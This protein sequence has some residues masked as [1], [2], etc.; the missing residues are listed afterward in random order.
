MMMPTIGKTNSTKSEKTSKHSI[1]RLYFSMLRTANLLIII[2]TFLVLKHLVFVPIFDLYSV[3][4][5][6]NYIQFSVMVTST[7]L[8][9]AAGYIS[10]DYFDIQADLVNKPQKQ[11]INR[12]MSAGKALAI[13]V[14]FSLF[15]I[16]LSIWLSFTM[17][18]MLP[19]LML[20]TALIVSWWYAASL[21]RSM[22]WGNIAVSC[23]TAG[24][25]VMAWIFEATCIQLPLQG[26]NYITLIV[27]AV[28][29]FA[30]LL[31]FIRE[32]VKDMEDVEGDKV[33]GCK[34][35]PII[36]GSRYTKTVVYIVS[37]I[38]IVLLASTQ[39]LLLKQGFRVTTLYLMLFVEL[40][41][42]WFM[43]KLRTTNNKAGFHYLSTSLKLIMLAG[44]FAV[45]VA[46]F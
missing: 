46:Q 11:Y 18:S 17:H 39:V 15:S 29:L 34:S 10:N 27:G 40:P 45:V 8:I 5:G 16:L 14:L 4:E 7:V 26:S 23:L 41:I 32:V 31:T 28:S 30:L 6:L 22:V 43:I 20:N 3:S 13:A 1:M 24:T 33:I 42:V 21:K 36:K 35:L 37:F 2:L 9:A 12:G 38:T 25:I 19:M 44:I